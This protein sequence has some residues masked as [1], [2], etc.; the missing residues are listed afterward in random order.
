MGRANVILYERMRV[1][2][3]V[4]C[5]TYESVCCANWHT[6]VC[7]YGME[8]Y[9]SMENPFKQKQN[10]TYHKLSYAH[11]QYQYIHMNTKL[12]LHIQGRMAVIKKRLLY[13]ICL[14]TITHTHIYY[15]N[16]CIYF[17]VIFIKTNRI[18]VK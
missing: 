14:C 13:F 2:V 9:K 12:P 1:G 4:V 18:T 5:K 11:W 16:N 17:V 6:H 15:I 10:K 7:M 3:Y 8:T